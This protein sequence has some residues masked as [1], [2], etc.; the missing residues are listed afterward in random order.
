MSI[1][2]GG[3]CLLNRSLLPPRLL[4]RMTHPRARRTN[5]ATPGSV[6]C[7]RAFLMT[8]IQGDFGRPGAGGNALTTTRR[9]PAAT[10]GLAPSGR[11][12]SP[13]TGKAVASSP[14]CARGFPK[15]KRGSSTT[16]QPPL[17]R[18]ETTSA[19]AVGVKLPKDLSQGSRSSCDGKL[20]QTRAQAIKGTTS[21]Q[22]LSGQ[23]VW[24]DHL[25]ERLASR[26]LAEVNFDGGSNGWWSPP[27]PDRALSL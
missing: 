24:P 3:Q 17:A 9:H 13:R 19:V 11:T 16:Y 2:G 12:Q 21:V 6:K 10:S 18:V 20:V 5:R 26:C 7:A 8:R 4:A 23:Q 25:A 15:W 22:G 27:W 1:Y 14:R